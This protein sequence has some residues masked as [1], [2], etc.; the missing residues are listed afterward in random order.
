MHKDNVMKQG[1]LY[2][3][4]VGP[5]DPELLTLKA[6]RIISQAD[7]IAIPD[8][9]GSTHTALDI[10]RRHVTSQELLYCP[11]PMVRNRQK[12][13]ENYAEVASRL[14][15]VLDEGKDIAFITL[16]DPTVYSTYMY[17]HQIVA[18]HNYHTQLVAGVTSFCATA[19]T[20]GVSLCER[21]ERLLVVPASYA[22]IE[23]CL[24]TDANLV[25]MKAGKDLGELKE[26]LIAHD[27]IDNA[28]LVENCGMQNER[29]FQQFADVDS[30][31]YF[32]VV[33]VKR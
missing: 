32:S 4:G 14:M 5:G 27:L 31:G 11:T 19:A 21:S 29:V 9:G 26:R 16:G 10:V 33:V 1:T 22:S 12:L 30:A 24:N 23:D 15:G 2:G 25:F 20:L 6:Q 13:S 18:Q 3:V 7:V 28:S 8:K 17:I